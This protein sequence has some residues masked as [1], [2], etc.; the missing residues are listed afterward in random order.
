MLGY[1]KALRTGILT[2]SL[3]LGRKG[4]MIAILGSLSGGPTRRILVTKK[5]QSKLYTSKTTEAA[6]STLT[7][8]D[9]ILTLP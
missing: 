4:D 3:S 5:D 6:V 1:T 2:I 7:L 8:Y 9:T